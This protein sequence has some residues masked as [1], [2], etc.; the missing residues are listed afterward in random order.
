MSAWDVSQ[1]C[2]LQGCFGEVQWMEEF[3]HLHHL[4]SPKNYCSSFSIMVDKV[5]QDFLNPKPSSLNPICIYIYIYAPYT[6][7][8]PFKVVCSAAPEP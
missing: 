8:N 2:G 4:G 7:I 1:N 3:L 5:L 6:P